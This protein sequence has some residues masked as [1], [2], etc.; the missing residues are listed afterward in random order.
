MLARSAWREALLAMVATVVASWP[1]QLLLDGSG[2]VWQMLPG[3]VA[4]AVT[5][6]LARGLRL[7]QLVVLVVPMLAGWTALAWVFVPQTLVLGLPWQASLAAA[8]DLVLAGAETIRTETVPAPERPG[9]A[10]IVAASMVGVGWAVDALAVTLRSPALAGMPLVL[11]LVFGASGTGEPLHPLYFLGAAGAWLLLMARQSLLAA[12]AWATRRRAA[13]APLPGDEAASPSGGHRRWATSLG[14]GSVV[15]AV[16]LAGLVP[17]LAPR[18]VLQGL[19]SASSGSSLVQF[20]ESFDLAADLRDR[21]QR[22]VLRYRA[23]DE[24]TPLRVVASHRY[25]GGQ[26]WPTGQQDEP[27]EGPDSLVE[28]DDVE[29]GA[30]AITVLANGLGAPQVAVPYPLVEA[31]FGDIEWEEDERTGAVRVARRPGSYEAT[32]AEVEGHLPDDV[33]VGPAAGTVEP[34]LLRVDPTSR[35]VVLDELG[36]VLEDAEP[37]IAANELMVAREIQSHLRGPDFR[38]SLTLAAPAPIAPASPDSAAPEDMTDPEYD[39]I[40]HFLTTKVGYC[41]HYA[42]AMVM[43]A[44]AAG[45]P[46]RLALGF[47]P[48][49]EQDDGSYVVVAA[50][51]HAW[52]ELYISGLGWTRFEPTPA[53]R[54]GTAPLYLT[55]ADIAA[56][57]PAPET[58]PGPTAEAPAEIPTQEQTDVA[59]PV[60][61]WTERAGRIAGPAVIAMAA[62]TAVLL[63]V[64]TAGRLRRTARRRSARDAAGRTEGEWRFLVDSLDDLGVPMPGG[65]TPRRAGAHYARRAGLA[66]DEKSALERVVA[67]VERA[68]YAPVTDAGETADGA[69][70]RDVRTVL[71]AAR[72][73]LAR[74]ER[75]A[76]ALWPRSGRE[77]LKAIGDRLGLLVRAA[78][79][80]TRLRRG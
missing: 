24:V 45:I 38:Y 9:L 40:T 67:R 57:L 20:T 77:A 78:D 71:H 31:D 54:T 51:A 26:W 10:F 18:A 42:T 61:S 30:H 12:R 28:R 14:A 52:P 17:H 19:G 79:R 36:E 62:I 56:P 53:V 27:H 47:L 58:T 44:R 32:F 3:L 59:A 22:P 29:R 74:R 65:A 35:D 76:V 66:G 39:P 33:G 41:T 80:T 21:S 50:D 13:P 6:S 46:A 15:L 37:E 25:A 8:G 68:R 7:P 1:V 69:M 34:D 5:G 23:E 4:V 75:I 49:A 16:V 64:P 2:W 73:Q 11:A 48:G 60:P 43:M 63:V 55:D 70:A 72:T